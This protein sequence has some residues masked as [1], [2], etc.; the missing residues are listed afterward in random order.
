[1]AFHH[2][3]VCS[4]ENGSVVFYHS[5]LAALLL[6]N[7]GAHSS[8]AGVQVGQ[9]VTASGGLQGGGGFG[10]P[11]QYQRKGLGQTFP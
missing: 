8:M 6:S 7:T 2:R 3:E 9:A 5:W 10:A 11:L 1:M 4:L